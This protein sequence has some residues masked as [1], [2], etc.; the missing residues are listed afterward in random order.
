M[1]SR[2]NWERAA[3]PSWGKK[4]VREGSLREEDAVSA[5]FQ[6][7]ELK[8]IQ[9]KWDSKQKFRNLVISSQK[10]P[11]G[12]PAHLPTHEGSPLEQPYGVSPALREEE[13]TAVCTNPSMARQFF[14]TKCFHIWTLTYHCPYVQ[15]PQS[16][17]QATSPHQQ[18]PGAV[19]VSSVCS[20][21][22]YS[23]LSSTVLE[24]ERGFEMLDKHHSLHCFQVHKA[25]CVESLGTKYCMMAMERENIKNMKIMILSSL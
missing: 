8:R 23:P 16:K 14:V 3:Y 7:Q 17:T 6:E 4:D 19:R 21:K 25:Q 15:T 12:H 5:D 18:T 2:R 13:L 1:F 24:L 11:I 10:G 22:Q 20:S 9:D